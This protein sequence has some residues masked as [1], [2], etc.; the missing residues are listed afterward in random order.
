[1]VDRWDNI[2]ILQAIDRIQQD[3]HRGAPITASNGMYLMYDSAARVSWSPSGGAALYRN[4]TSPVSWD[5]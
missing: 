2:E 5:C 1:M 3:R 4:C